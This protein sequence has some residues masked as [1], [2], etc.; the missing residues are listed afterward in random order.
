MN[1]TTMLGSVVLA[2]IFV[3][4]LGSTSAR[5]VQ[6]VQLPCSIFQEVSTSKLLSPFE[7]GLYIAAVGDALNASIADVDA[8]TDQLPREF[9]H[10][11]R[12][13]FKVEMQLEETPTS[14]VQPAPLRTSATNYLRIPCATFQEVATSNFL[15]PF[16]N[17]LYIE[18]FVNILNGVPV[19]I[20]D[21]RA[22]FDQLPR[23][24][25]FPMLQG[26]K[27]G[28]DLKELASS[29]QP[30]AVQTGASQ[31]LQCNSFQ[32]TAVS[33]FLSPFQTG[34][35]LEIY[36]DIINGVKVTI[37]TVDACFG[38]LPREFYNPLKLGFQVGTELKAFFGH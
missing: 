22:C 35:F 25:V 1:R 20:D 6:P 32:D 9:H 3:A 16:E 11:L 15:S 18:S 36:V 5:A 21:A 24:F 17:G 12:L 33:H 23:E 34:L 14:S 7:T 27:V 30:M 31:Q 28:I 38:E 2:L 13:G 4:N 10:P 26:F 29:S 8:C 37:D 19:N